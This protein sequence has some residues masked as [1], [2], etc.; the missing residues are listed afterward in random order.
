MDLDLRQAHA[1]EARIILDL[2]IGAAFTRLQTFALQNRFGI[3]GEQLLSYGPCQFPTLGF[4][5]ERY[6]RVKDFRPETFWYIHLELTRHLENGD[7]EVAEF[8]WKRGHIFNNAIV[9]ALYSRVLENPRARVLN[10]TKKDT[11]KW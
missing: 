7:S 4:V 5:V 10:V 3:S 9:V 8:R 1:V 11:K 2:K 6:L